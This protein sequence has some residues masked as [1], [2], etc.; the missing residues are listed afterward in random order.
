MWRSRPVKRGNRGRTTLPLRRRAG[1]PM[2]EFDRLPGAL[3]AWLREAALPWGPRS[4]RR[5]YD[6]ALRRTGDAALALED[7]DRIEA[8]LIARDARRIWGDGHPLAVLPDPRAPRLPVPS[9]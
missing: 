9:R 6:R 1:D 7:L 4:V 2:R 5:A 3:R 8:R